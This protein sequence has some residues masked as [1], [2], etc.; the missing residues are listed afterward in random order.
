MAL[1]AARIQTLWFSQLV[2]QIPPLTVE[3]HYPTPVLSRPNY[4]ILQTARDNQRRNHS[5]ELR[6]SSSYA[7]KTVLSVTTLSSAHQVE[8]DAVHDDSLGA[9]QHPTTGVIQPPS[10]T[11]GAVHITPAGR[12]RSG[13][14]RCIPRLIWGT[15][16]RIRLVA[17]CTASHH[18]AGQRHDGHHPQ[19][20]PRGD[21]SLPVR[22]G[23]AVEAL[24]AAAASLPQRRCPSGWAS[25]LRAMNEDYTSAHAAGSAEV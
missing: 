17:G 20:H 24:R 14:G 3:L 13:D 16:G 5:G 7:R 12:S 25:A 21:Q 4:T 15:F 19:S 8:H 1:S 6:V 2:S 22:Q 23:R 9:T 18:R 11:Y 10:G